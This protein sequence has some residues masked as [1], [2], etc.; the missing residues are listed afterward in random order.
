MSDMNAARTALAVVAED[1]PMI[2]LDLAD[3][4][5]DAGFDVLETATAAGALRHLSAGADVALLVTDVQMPG[6]MDG[7]ALARE[8]AARWPTIDI[9]VCSAYA[10]PQP[11]QLPDG[12]RFLDKPYSAELVVRLLR[13]MGLAA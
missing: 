11:G 9:I 5:A 1:E 3:T 7:F 2:R 4:L 10:K 12:A 6:G 8:A 13:E